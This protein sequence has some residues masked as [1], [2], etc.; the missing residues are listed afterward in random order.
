VI[1]GF[2]TP[3][4]T[5][6]YGTGAGTVPEH[7]RVHGGLTLSSVG[8]GTYLGK[9]DP[10]TDRAYGEAVT[11]ALRRGVNVIDSAVNYRHQRSER[12]IGAALAALV[13]SGDITREQVVLATKGGF[14]PFD[15]AAPA[16]PGAYLIETYVRPGIFGSDDIVGT[17]HCMTPRYLADQLE[18]SRANLG[19]ETIDIYYLHN[20]EM[21][22]SAVSRR[23]FLARMQ[24]AFAFL[25]GAV[26]AGKI[27][28]YGTATWD[29]YRLDPSARDYLS[30]AELVDLAVAEG[31]PSHHFRV[32]QL[33]YNLAMTEAFTQ[34]NQRV[35]GETVSVLDAA[36]HFGIYTMASASIYQGQLARGLP[37]MLGALMPGLQTDAQRALQFVRSTPGIGTALIGMKQASHVDENTA[38]RAV[39]PVPWERF[40]TLFQEG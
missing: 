37:E 5:A 15:G 29:G 7:F 17:S 21:Q 14:I 16:D 11:Q 25:E 26:S 18:R 4:G 3:E 30:L 27:R 12:S 22:L 24:A 32:I 8:I 28:L 20:P 23:T 33:P 6:A 34:P 10:A 38:L 19:V 9:E 1:T 39:A 35:E 40:R 13:R 31:G 2:A 36:D